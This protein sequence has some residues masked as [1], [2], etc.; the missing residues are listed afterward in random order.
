MAYI[1]VSL[2]KL[3]RCCKPLH[4]FTKMNKNTRAFTSLINTTKVMHL[5]I[6]APGYCLVHISMIMYMRY[7]S[8]FTRMNVYAEYYGVPYV[9]KLYINAAYW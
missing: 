6:C 9:S 8:V 3:E 4:L 1:A 5:H 2:S 7:C